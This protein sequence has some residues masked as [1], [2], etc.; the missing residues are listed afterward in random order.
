MN[1]L[2]QRLICPACEMQIPVGQ[3]ILGVDGKE[4]CR[5]Y[6]CSRVAVGL[7]KYKSNVGGTVSDGEGEK[8]K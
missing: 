5:K 3:G 8:R 7:P 4:Y 2:T 1:D 6:R